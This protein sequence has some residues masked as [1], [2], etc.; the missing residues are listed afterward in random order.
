MHQLL[1]DIAAAKGELNAEESNARLQDNG[2]EEERSQLEKEDVVKISQRVWD[3]SSLNVSASKVPQ[4]MPIRSEAEAAPVAAELDIDAVAELVAEIAS[5][6]PGLTADALM[7]GIKRDL[8]D[9][10][11]LIGDIDWSEKD[12]ERLPEKLSALAGVQKLNLKENKKL[13]SLPERFGDLTSL[14]DLDMAV[15]TSVVSLPASFCRL[16]NLKKLDLSAP[17]SSMKLESL[18]ERFRDLKNLQE[19]NMA[20]CPAGRNMPAALKEQLQAQGCEIDS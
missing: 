8:D 1:A 5:L 19:L 15:C 18:P 16:S 11:R 10:S 2:D 20:H 6:N 14:E 12:I 7:E 4:F 9:P 17:F 13:A 3:V